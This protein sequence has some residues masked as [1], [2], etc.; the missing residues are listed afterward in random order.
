MTRL[1]CFP[2]SW[3]TPDTVE[4]AKPI[5]PTDFLAY[6]LPAVP[7]WLQWVIALLTLI[8]VLTPIVI[9][10]WRRY[11][12]DRWARLSRQLAE[13]TAAR[14]R[15]EAVLIKQLI[16]DPPRL[17][18]FSAVT[19][20]RMMQGVF[21]MLLAIITLAAVEIRAEIEALDMNEEKGKSVTHVLLYI[22]ITFG[23]VLF[24]IGSKNFLTLKAIANLDKYKKRTHDRLYKLYTQT[25]AKPPV[26]ELTIREIFG[27]D[28]PSPGT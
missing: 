19:Q 27:D 12:S 21:I 25:E 24:V 10:L 14:I 17:T 5:T 23:Y 2:F 28:H 1:A 7:N 16:D 11:I 3:Y 20:M 15:A 6:D 18:A 22:V 8:V 4:I 26:D 13:K 9:W